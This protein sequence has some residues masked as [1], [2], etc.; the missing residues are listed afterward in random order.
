MGDLSQ[1]W[2]EKMSRMGWRPNEIDALVEKYLGRYPAESII[3]VLQTGDGAGDLIGVGTSHVQDARR[4]EKTIVGFTVGGDNSIMIR[5]VIAP[6]GRIPGCV[7]IAADRFIACGMEKT[8]FPFSEIIAASGGERTA[9][10]ANYDL[11][12]LHIDNYSYSG[13]IHVAKFER[14]R[15]DNLNC[16]YE[17]LTIA[18]AVNRK[19][20]ADGVG[21]ISDVWHQL[22]RIIIT[23]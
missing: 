21:S 11:Q 8:E 4:I 17:D 9:A 5:S 20:A 19:A 2:N 10:A 13:D 6:E 18:F 15:Q 16:G 12:K 1:R 22:E 23:K 3:G 14:N 7:F